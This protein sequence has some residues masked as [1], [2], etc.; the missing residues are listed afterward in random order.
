MVQKL[1]AYSLGR[2]LEAFDLPAVRKVR[3]DAASGD[4][5]WSSIILGI[6]TSTPFQLRRPVSEAGLT[7]SAGGNPGR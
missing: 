1:L 4:Y 2:E 6:V 7:V 5:R 3:Q